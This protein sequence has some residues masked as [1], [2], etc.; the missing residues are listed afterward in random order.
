MAYL[1]KSGNVT[2]EVSEEMT[3]K[4]R[5]AIDRAAPWLVP[6]V[7]AEVEDVVYEARQVWPV[8]DYSERADGRRGPHEKRAGRTHSRDLFETVTIIEIGQ[9]AIRARI[10]NKAA[11]WLF[12]KG[13][14]AT[15][16][17]R[18]PLRKRSAKLAEELAKILRDQMGAR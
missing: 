16:E 8:G 15:K 2:V 9:G 13:G 17:I 11:Y 1:V 7:E 10:T 12:I 18:V 14:P 5:A 3:R 4:I 6:A